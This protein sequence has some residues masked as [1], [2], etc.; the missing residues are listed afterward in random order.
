MH[1]AKCRRIK[2]EKL[3][4]NRLLYVWGWRCWIP[5]VPK[6]LSMARVLGKFSLAKLAAGRIVHLIIERSTS[7]REIILQMSGDSDEQ[8]SVHT[9]YEYIAAQHC[10]TMNQ[11]RELAQTR[12]RELHSLWLIERSWNWSIVFST[13]TAPLPLTFSIR[14]I[15]ANRIEIKDIIRD[16]VHHQF[17]PSYPFFSSSIIVYFDSI[18]QTLH[19]KLKISITLCGIAR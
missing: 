11:D 13:L 16:L 1:T 2:N 9:P 3:L 14:L 6:H 10:D 5:V 19:N 12:P 17:P 15:T 7:Q 18:L 8:L 4:V